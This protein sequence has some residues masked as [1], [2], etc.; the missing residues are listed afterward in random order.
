MTFVIVSKLRSL[1]EP[2][3][4]E[5]VHLR[6]LLM[7]HQSCV[8]NQAHEATTVRLYYRMCFHEQAF[9]RAELD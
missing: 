6:I 2:I 8:N 1:I 7:G 9:F 3:L 5:T 4:I